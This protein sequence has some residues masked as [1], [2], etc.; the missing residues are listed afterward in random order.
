M[1]KGFAQ[2][3]MKKYAP[4]KA[5]KI[6]RKYIK[7]AY[8]IHVLWHGLENAKDTAEMEDEDFE[9]EDELR[10]VENYERQLM[11][12]YKYSEEI[13]IDDDFYKEVKDLYDNMVANIDEPEMSLEE[14]LAAFDQKMDS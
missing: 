14:V 4:K 10:A 13:N 6:L 11:E 5:R 7:V 3:V 8:R 9:F 1:E 2:D 12:I